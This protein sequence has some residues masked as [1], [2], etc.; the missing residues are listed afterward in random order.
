MINW[1]LK[2]ADFT[3]FR[4]PYLSEST[5]DALSIRTSNK[6]QANDI[7]KSLQELIRISNRKDIIQAIEF[8]SP[9]LATKI[10]QLTTELTVDNLKLAASIY[11]Y[12]TRMSTRSTPFGAFSSVMTV[13]NKEKTKIN[14]AD[15]IRL[16]LRVD[17]GI[18]LELASLALQRAIKSNNL[19]LLVR[20]NSSLYEIGDEIR[21]VSKMRTKDYVD[22][23]LDEV[24]FSHAI[25]T[26]LGLSEQ[27]ISVKKLVAELG[28]KYDQVGSKK[29]TVFVHDLLKNQ[30]LESNLGIVI[31][32]SNS[33]QELIKRSLASKIDQEFVQRLVKI[34]EL[35]TS[36]TTLD[37]ENIKE[38]LSKAQTNLEQL[39]P[40]EFDMK[41]WIHVDSF[42][43][44]HG[45]SMGKDSIHA[46]SE[47]VSKLAD[48]FWRPNKV[49]ADFTNKFVE[50]YGE[51]EVSL[52]EALDIDNGI[53][54]GQKRLGR[55]PLLNGVLSVK[56][57][58]SIDV[59][60]APIDQFF[61]K[62]IIEGLCNN[63]TTVCIKS[64]EL[65]KYKS[66]LPKT[67]GYDDS[68]SIHGT[69]LQG[70]NDE[71]LYKINSISGPS[72]IMLLGR[73]CCGDVE[74]ASA[75]KNF[76][77]EEQEQNPDFV[78]AEI[79]H[80]PQSRTANISCRPSL[81]EKEIVYGPGDS[82]LTATNQINCTD[83]YL[84]V[85]AGRL[86]LFSKTLQK[87]V[88]PR[89]ASAHNTSGL[90][91]PIYQFLHSLQGSN[92][93]FVGM[94][95]N[96][97]IDTLQYL[98]EIR[99][100][101]LVLFERRWLISSEEIKKIQ[102]GNSHEEKIS[103]LQD[104]IKDRNI[105]RYVALSEGD[106]LLDFDLHSPFSAL[107]FINEIKRKPV[108]KI[109]ASLKGRNKNLGADAQRAYRHEFVIPCFM[110]KVNSQKIKAVDFSREF[111]NIKDAKEKSSLPGEKWKYLKIYTGE[112][113][114]DKL[115]ANHLAPLANKLRKQGIIK[116]WFFIRYQDPDFHLRFRLKLV[117][118]YQTDELNQVLYQPLKVLYKQG[119]IQKIVEDCY[120]PEF[121]RYGGSHILGACEEVFYMNSVVVSELI[122]RTY[123]EPNK[124]DIR[125]K[126]CL[127]L[128]WQVT[129][130]ICDSFEQAEAFFK[131]IAAAYDQE[132]NADTE[133]KKKLNLNYR[134]AMKE[135]ANCLSM[136]FNYSSELF[137]DADFLTAYSRKLSNLKN[138]CEKYNQDV[139]MILS[140][141][142]H[143]DCNRIFVIS[144]RANEWVIYHYLARYIRTVIARKF[145]ANKDVV[146]GF[147]LEKE[148]ADA[149]P[150]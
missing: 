129:M 13:A 102:S 15:S 148:K 1:D 101:N 92:G 47:T 54:F 12:L 18:V 41:H 55:S 43:S 94:T 147:S 3:V 95:L 113:S 48:F 125:W 69:V 77:H 89:L 66:L 22:F 124:D 90:N 8:A 87:E 56:Q 37:D 39:L 60:W 97:A 141:I 127:R 131:R 40:E 62:K 44:G 33:F 21:F 74:L 14:I 150:V 122:K 96:R 34:D 57:N 30:L 111:T 112:A 46:L 72:G 114:A 17:N 68:M 26:A 100:D 107:M 126:I 83:L 134:E 123:L 130:E 108:V 81:R 84:K 91:L 139:L 99:I 20:K 109:V 120:V 2:V 140:S 6:E 50:M 11:K 104:L 58:L 59:N 25:G 32:S 136:E 103:L 70:E 38:K 143:M 73:F 71:T 135:V 16:F 67:A 75:C 4:T 27:W 9:S 63:E 128:A 110:K 5:I 118:D 132:F 28:M 76:A 133:I 146:A 49:L 86:L 24:K 119:Q 149:E 29:L 145:I 65:E 121:E 80:I 98:P 93:W 88:R 64:E 106:N 51:A 19:D 82:S 85:V 61:M 116:N 53:Q 36:L 79:I 45:S 7:Q 42:R 105:S 115:I 31:S 117:N 138:L 144:Q 137:L 78:Y 142:I 52:L 10:S 35:L 23:K